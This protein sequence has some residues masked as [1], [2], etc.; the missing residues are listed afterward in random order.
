MEWIGHALSLAKATVLTPLPMVMRE[1][2]TQQW[3]WD[4]GG[5]SMLT[6]ASLCGFW[7][8][9]A[10]EDAVDVENRSPLHWAGVCQGPGEKHGCREHRV[11]REGQARA[12]R[13][14][15]RRAWWSGSDEVS[16][17][18]V[19]PLVPH[20]SQPPPAVPQVCSCC[21]TTRPSWTS[22]IT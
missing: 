14:Q 3:E 13:G 18:S 4:E 5:N 19:N 9:G 16:F 15:G 1:L 22:W 12:E 17:A 6:A 7:Q 21:V 2:V 8:H 10:N 11:E 20:P